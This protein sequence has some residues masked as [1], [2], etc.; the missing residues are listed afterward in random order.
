[1]KNT[2][3]QTLAFILALALTAG[4][5]TGCGKGDTKDDNAGKGR[6]IE[7]DIE[8]PFKDGEGGIS[9]S[10]SK[11]GNPLLFGSK[12]SEVNRYEYKDGE[13]K[14]TPVKWIAELYQDQ[15]PYLVD[16][17]ETADAHRYF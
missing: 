9:F 17:E 13:W 3:K 14:E 10:K 16:M 1:M 15:P 4:L 8:L 5:L 11:D 2:I 7:K 6:Y 12:G